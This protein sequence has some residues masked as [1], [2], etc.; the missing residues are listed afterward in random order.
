MIKTLF[1]IFSE[2]T[3]MASISISSAVRLGYQVGLYD[4][5]SWKT[6]DSNEVAMRQ[7]V[8]WCL[9]CLDRHVA[10]VCGVPYLIRESDFRVNEPLVVQ[11]TGFSP[12]A[13]A[14]GEIPYCSSILYLRSTIKWARLSA[15]IWDGIFGIKAANPADREFVAAIDARVTLLIQD[16]PSQFQ[17]SSQTMP[18]SDTDGLPRHVYRQCMIINLVSWPYETLDRIA[19]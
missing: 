8:F 6:D 2:R 3:S 9:Y 1:L 12:S 18:S 11:D 15:E 5:T 13:S 16:L 4:Q 19:H 7:R 17:W 14:S 10:L